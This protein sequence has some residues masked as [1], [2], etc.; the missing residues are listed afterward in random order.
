MFIS[1]LVS[2]A[3]A[4]D[5][6]GFVELRVQAF[7]GVDGTPWQLVERVRPRFSL[8]LGEHAKLVTTLE[9]GL[10]QGRNLQDE[11]QRTIDDSDF[12]PVLAQG[13]CAWPPDEKNT[14]LRVNRASDYLAVDRL[15]LD[16]Y[17]K[18]ID[19]RVGRQALQWGSGL[20][21]NP[22]DPFPQVLF[23]EPWRPRAGVNAVRATVPFG[24]TSNQVT[25]VVAS[26]DT[27]TAIRAAA[28]ATVNAKGADVSVL[29]AYRGVRDQPATGI[30]GLDLKGT[31]GVGYWFEGALHVESER[32]FEEFVVGVDYSFPVLDT[33]TVAAQYY[34]NGGGQSP[35]VYGAQYRGTAGLVPP[36]CDDPSAAGL[37]ASATQTDPFAP[38][39]QGTDYA[40]LN[41]ALRV[42]PDLSV[43]AT[44]F[45]NLRDGTG[46]AIATVMVSPV[47]NLD[48]SATAQVPY[49][50]WG[51]TG[52]FKP[53]SGDLVL[54]A[55]SPGG[56]NLAVDLNGLVA[57]ATVVLWSRYAF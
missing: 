23:A 16:V 56:G 20:L 55:P 34:R 24:K 22:T 47:K 54:T 44:G 3:I 21:V 14:L 1:V 28:R 25:G 12:G 19:V 50:A 42:N 35:E 31:L 46:F 32:V 36:T 52:E 8:D 38:F 10:S 27:F 48:F 11:A 13:G 39:V 57:D 15:Y 6:A 43:S 18:K 49:R 53:G 37:F 9:A 7:V 26:D 29:G 17:A 2:A 30:V 5:A 33:W 40:L 51:R 4:S 45:Q 41:T